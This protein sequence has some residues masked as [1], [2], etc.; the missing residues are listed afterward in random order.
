[1]KTIG[2][3]EHFIIPEL[4]KY[5]E[6][7]KNLA[8]AGAWEDAARRLTDILELRIPTM[9]ANGLDMQVLSLTAPGVQA[10]SDAGSLPTT[11]RPRTSF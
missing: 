9:D 4:F 7:T 11:Q 3:E 5:S 2:L 6:S 10:E 8:G 1:M